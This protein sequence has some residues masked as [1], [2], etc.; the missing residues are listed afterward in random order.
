MTMARPADVTGPDPRARDPL[1]DVSRSVRLQFWLAGTLGPAI[2]RLLGRTVRWRF[3]I[4]PA[5]RAI[6]DAGTPHIWAF[7]HGQIL[8][9]T[10][11]H[12]GRGAQVMVSHNKDGELITRVI[13]GLGFGTVRGSSSRGGV[14]ALRG[15]LTQLRRG[16]AVA[17]TPDGPRG[18][19]HHVQDGVVAVAARGGAPILP[20]G[21]HLSGVWRLDS[22]DRFE[23]MKPFA[24]AVVTFDAPI[25]VPRDATD[26][27]DRWRTEIADRLHA[28]NRHAE[29]EARRGR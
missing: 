18:P 20:L 19:R 28:A 3:V 4:D 29:E 23:I 11:T 22:W 25:V 2:V 21:V 17:I 14:A 27:L 8:P 12:R 6:L 16:R 7:W 9:L 1:A 13:E 5:T 24:R 10:Y 15:L 26:D